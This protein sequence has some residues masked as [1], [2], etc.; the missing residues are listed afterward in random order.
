MGGR[1]ALGEHVADV[2]FVHHLGATTVLRCRQP[3]VH[4]DAERLGD[5]G[6][7]ILPDGAARDAADQLAEDE[8]ERHH[9]VALRGAWRPPRRG[10]GDVLAHPVPVGGL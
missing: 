8:A 5:L 7:Q 4:V 1:I 9:V 3:D 10:L 6:A 2:R